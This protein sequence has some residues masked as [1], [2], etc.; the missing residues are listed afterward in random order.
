MAALN[1]RDPMVAATALAEGLG[2]TFCPYRI[3]TCAVSF[4]SASIK[5]FIVILCSR[6]YV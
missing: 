6:P 1:G 4:L 3:E 5:S 2:V